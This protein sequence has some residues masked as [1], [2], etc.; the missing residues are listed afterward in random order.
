MSKSDRQPRRDVGF[1]FLP[2]DEELVV[3]YLLSKLIGLP[4]PHS[5][6]YVNDCNI[7][8]DLEPWE[9]WQKF[10]GG[11]QEDD[12]DGGGDERKNDLYF[13][14][15]LKKRSATGTNI[16]RSVGTNG[17][18][19]HGE[20]SGKESQTPDGLVSWTVKR[21][22]YRPKKSKGGQKEN[23]P[24]PTSWIMHE[25]CLLDR[26]IPFLGL[27]AAAATR[28][29]VCRIRKKEDSNSRKRKNNK[30]P[31]VIFIDL[32]EDDDCND[33]VVAESSVADQS[34]TN[35][36]RK[37]GGEGEVCTSSSCQSEIESCFSEV[38]EGG[39]GGNPPDEEEAV[40]S[41]VAEIERCLSEVNED[42]GG[43]GEFG[44]EAVSSYAAELERCLSEVKEDCGGGGN[45]GDEGEDCLAEVEEEEDCSGGDD[46]EDDDG[47]L[48]QAEIDRC[49][50]EEEL[51]PPSEFEALIQRFLSTKEPPVAVMSSAVSVPSY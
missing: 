35:K 45:G 14:T 23:G 49:L 2:T 27:D 39:G 5:G 32:D 7:Y 19:W 20:D 26:P 9:I 4:P 48:L 29:V 28:L 30:S 10:R 22:S 51:A 44:E 3:G 1:R 47:S 37:V 17:G 41:Y 25:Y 15:P 8:G 18:S 38:K 12:N 34:S 16:D 42:C 36:R 33:A 31:K 43:G 40:F 24:G 11:E 13:F 50:P 21:F 46:D 6:D